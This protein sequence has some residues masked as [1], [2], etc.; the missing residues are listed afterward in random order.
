MKKH[1]ID[2]PTTT[3]RHLVLFYMEKPTDRFWKDHGKLLLSHHQSSE[4]FFF[5]PR[6]TL[7]LVCREIIFSCRN[8]VLSPLFPHSLQRFLC[9]RLVNILK[10]EYNTLNAFFFREPIFSPL[11]WGSLGCL[12]LRLKF[13]WIDVFQKLRQNTS[14][15]KKKWTD[16]YICY[17]FVVLLSVV[18]G[19]AFVCVYYAEMKVSEESGHSF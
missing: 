11:A 13:G 5:F 3:T 16:H 12:K 2:F 9:V 17:C 1:L 19:V 10:L 6:K 14:L 15:N 18:V 7:Y 4:G 8:H